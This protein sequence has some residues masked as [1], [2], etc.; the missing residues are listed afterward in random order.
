MSELAIPR[1]YG[2]IVTINVDPQN[3]FMPGGALAVKDGDEVVPTL[4]ALNDWTRK[5]RGSLVFTRD[6]HPDGT[7][8]FTTN[9]GPWQPHCRQYR[10]GAAFH[11][12]LRIEPDRGD[13]IASK[14]MSYDDDGYSGYL[15]QI[16]T[17]RLVDIVADLPPSE[18]TVAA[19]I[20]RMI[21]TERT[22][23]FAIIVGG[24]ATDYCV[25]AT[26]RDAIERTDPYRHPD[27]SRTVDVIIATDAVRAVDIQ[28]G[29]GDRAIAA[30]IEAGAL[31]MTSQEIIS[32]SVL[33]ERSKR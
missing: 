10:A 21:Q 26:A 20:D 2:D 25:L 13:T 27:G 23:R 24:L 17:G 28:P 30:L 31:A 33:S 32:G 14:G 15:A 18:R 16:D 11:D 8:H 12:D 29:D 22:R 7:A 3:D 9:G 4:N 19:A 6:W 1:T 5:H